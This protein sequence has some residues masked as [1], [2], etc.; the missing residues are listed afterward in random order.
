MKGLE[1]CLKWNRKIK[2]S[3]FGF[4]SSI[5]RLS[6]CIK[7]QTLKWFLLL[8]CKGFHLGLNLTEANLARKWSLKWNMN[9]LDQITFLVFSPGKC[10][11]SDHSLRLCPPPH[12]IMHDWKQCLN[13]CKQG[14]TFSIDLKRPPLSLNLEPKVRYFKKGR[15]GFGFSFSEATIKET[16][17]AFVEQ[18][19]NIWLKKLQLLLNYA[20]FHVFWNEKLDFVWVAWLL[21]GMISRRSDP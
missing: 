17:P 12:P 4:F 19:E 15:R 21:E 13:V 7:R 10:L 5:K 8:F 20:C 3:S 1:V 18:G 11:T 14:D 2:K 9:I 16:D 6:K